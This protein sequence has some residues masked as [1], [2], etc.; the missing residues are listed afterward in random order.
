MWNIREKSSTDWKTS[1]LWTSFY[2]IMYIGRG[3]RLQWFY[4]EMVAK[5]CQAGCASW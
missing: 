5:T 4:P 3:Q 2:D 1:L